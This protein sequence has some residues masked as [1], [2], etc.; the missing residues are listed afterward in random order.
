MHAA[1]FVL[2]TILFLIVAGRNFSFEYIIYPQCF[3]INSDVCVSKAGEFRRNRI[4]GTSSIVR[5]RPIKL[6]CT[7]TSQISER[8]LF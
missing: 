1:S 7:R 8:N 3:V 2:N 4:D 6:E 5:D